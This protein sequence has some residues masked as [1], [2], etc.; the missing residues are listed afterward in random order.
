MIIRLWQAEIRSNRMEQ[1]S[2]WERTRSLPMFKQQNG[3]LGVLFL[4][5]D[6]FCFALSFWRDMNAVADLANSELY[7]ET[8]KA[9]EDSGMLIGKAT[10]RVF[11]AVEGFVVEDLTAV[12]DWNSEKGTQ[13][14]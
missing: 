1:Y 12:L 9:Y 8:S 6:A 4:R 5:S 11:E 3:C 10:L 14:P 7:N 13:C 2:Q